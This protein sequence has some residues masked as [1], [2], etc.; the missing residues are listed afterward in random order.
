MKKNF[1]LSL[2]LLLTCLTG[3]AQWNKDSTINVAVSTAA[4]YQN[5]PRAVPDGSGGMFVCWASFNGSY[6]G[7]IYVQHFNK[8]GIA[9]WAT[10]GVSV[11]TGQ[12]SERPRLVADGAGGVIVAWIDHRYLTASNNE[13]AD[14]Y[15][16]KINANGHAVWA[17][18]GIIIDSNPD[19]KAH[20]SMASDGKGGAFIAWDQFYI[21][22]ANLIF[23]EH[24]DSDGNLLWGIQAFP[25]RIEYSSS[26]YAYEPQL[27]AD[28]VGGV[29]ATWYD[30]RDGTDNIYAQRLNAAGTK[31]WPYTDIS[32]C[33]AS[34]S[35][36]FPQIISDGKNGAIITWSDDRFGY[37]D[38]TFD[39]FAQKLDSSG[40]KKWL[41]PGDPNNN[42]IAVCTT[43]YRQF[44]PHLTSDSAGGAYIAWAD[45]NY[46]YAEYMQ[47]INNNGDTVF[48]K[49]GIPVVPHASYTGAVIFGEDADPAVMTTDNEGNAIIAWPDVPQYNADHDIRA[50]KVSKTGTLLWQAGGVAVCTA[51]GSQ[52]YPQIIPTVNNGA[53]AVWTDYRDTANYAAH[54]YA[55]LISATGTLPVTLRPLT[56]QY[57]KTAI[58]LQWQTVTETNSK[59]FAVERGATPAKFDSI[60]FVAA[61][62]NTATGQLYSFIDVQPLAT[63]GFYRL[64]MVDRDGKYAYSNTI[65]MKPANA[66]AL[67]HIYPNP[68]A[69]YITINMPGVNTAD[70][71]V[72]YDAQGRTVKQW[73]RTPVNTAFSVAQLAPGQYTVS[74]VVGKT[75]TSSKIIVQ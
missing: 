8:S 41:T 49:N 53:I 65:I 37:L 7:D 29:I 13:E 62:G 31:L 6:F 36:R 24:V 23:G 18:N 43:D 12:H 55:S 19:V 57:V 27:V 48:K 28:G 51:V 61:T 5:Y 58:E 64:K 66:G 15:A 60:G 38:A 59:Y 75:V 46:G 42:G 34:Y 4:A 11:D 67:V 50:Q 63:D 68:A 21:S 3:F 1:T 22:S 40:N 16:Q 10:N 14:V 52:D 32:I 44:F 69:E 47:R 39:I 9:Q 54:I 74:V 35:Q 33:S 45:E 17:N 70:R 20:I 71:V 72:I 56:G 30:S 25:E 2:V 26:Q 73:Q